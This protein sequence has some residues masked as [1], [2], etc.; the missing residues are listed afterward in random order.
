MGEEIPCPLVARQPNLGHQ[1]TTNGVQGGAD[2]KAMATIVNGTSAGGTLGGVA[3]V[4]A[5]KILASGIVAS[6]ELGDEGYIMT[7]VGGRPG[8]GGVK[9][10]HSTEEIALHSRACPLAL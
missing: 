4:E 6:Q 2:E 3:M 7:G 1:T 8:Q 5:M 10:G 9:T